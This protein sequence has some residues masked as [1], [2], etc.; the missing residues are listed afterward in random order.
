MKRYGFCL[1]RARAV[2]A[3]LEKARKR[4]RSPRC[5]GVILTCGS[6]LVG[7]AAAQGGASI[8]DATERQCWFAG[9]TVA[10][11]IRVVGETDAG[12][13][14][15]WR[16]LMGG[17]T[18]VRR[19]LQVTDAMG[20]DG[21]ELEFDLPAVAPGVTVDMSLEATWVNPVTGE[22]LASMRK[23]IT[24]FS[25][26]VFEGRSEW[27]DGLDIRLFDPEKRTVRLFEDLDIPHR[28]TR[29]VDGFESMTSGILIVGEGC[30]LAEYRGLWSALMAAS[31]RGV[32]VICLA[33]SEGVLEFPVGNEAGGSTPSS[34]QLIGPSAPTM[35]D[36]RFD[37]EGWSAR[38]A[39][40][41]VALLPVGVRKGGGLELKKQHGGWAWLEY[42]FGAR[43]GRLV[44]C[45]FELIRHWEASPVPRY[46][47]LKMLEAASRTASENE[48]GARARQVMQEER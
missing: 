20:D 38:A 14:L 15:N 41:P 43:S 24:S 3:P 26:E 30:S 21:V 23:P 6:L 34:V 5:T 8:V 10:N 40:A 1:S 22:V 28:Y 19:E 35:L 37:V 48:N 47:L 16:V 12:T 25:P 13:R 44:L 2:D 29:N 31:G 36:K 39:V 45:Q 46:M 17:R 11:V 27:L 7:A 4:V 18:I 42:G 32:Y 33:L 9:S